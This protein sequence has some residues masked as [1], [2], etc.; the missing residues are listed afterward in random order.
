VID[1][2]T[3]TNIGNGKHVILEFERENR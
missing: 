3:Q 1:S 2:F